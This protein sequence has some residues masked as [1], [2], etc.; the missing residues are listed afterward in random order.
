MI[1]KLNIPEDDWPP[2]VTFSDTI[3]ETIKKRVAEQ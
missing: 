1:L 3:I 2:N